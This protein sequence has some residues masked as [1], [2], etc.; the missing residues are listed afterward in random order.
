MRRAHGCGGRKWESGGGDSRRRDSQESIRPGSS[1][2][3]HI[4]NGISQAEGGTYKDRKIMMHTGT[5]FFHKF[6]KMTKSLE[7]KSDKKGKVVIEPTLQGAIHKGIK[8]LFGSQLSS[9]F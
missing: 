3:T 2:S 7:D 9:R 5:K 8:I 6:R 4:A 1:L